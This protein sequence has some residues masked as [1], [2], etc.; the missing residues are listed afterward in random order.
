[1]KTKDLSP[2]R[3]KSIPDFQQK[4]DWARN[5]L[6]KFGS[7]QHGQHKLSDDEIMTIWDKVEPAWLEF[8]KSPSSYTH[9]FY[10]V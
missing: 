7:G 8:I 1:M 4:V 3:V 2:S 6:S 5:I 9:V 10:R